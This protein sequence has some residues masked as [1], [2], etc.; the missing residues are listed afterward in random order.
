MM[1]I[2]QLQP[3]RC[4]FGRIQAALHAMLAIKEGGKP[5]CHTLIYVLYMRACCQPQPTLPVNYI[6]VIPSLSVVIQTALPAPVSTSIVH[7][8]Q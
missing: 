6:D 8:A 1:A 7:Q 5:L 2:S 4:Q 3:Q